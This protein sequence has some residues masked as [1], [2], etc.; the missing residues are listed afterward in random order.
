M[1]R[2]REPK[3][4]QRPT[5]RFADPAGPADPRG[6][7]S[8]PHPASFRDPD[9]FVFRRE[10]V[11]H[12]HVSGPGRVAYDGLMQS[13]LYE[14]LTEAR[15]LLPHAEDDVALSPEPDAYRVLRPRQLPFIS[16]PY[17]WS[18]NQL[19][20]AA[21]LTLEIERRALSR[22][23]TLK[24]ASAYNVQYVDGRSTFI[25]SLS[26]A[27]YVEGTPWAA[28]RQFCGHFLAPLA[29]MSRV[30]LRLGTLLG[31]YLDG[32]PLD[33]AADLLPRRSRLTVSFGV[34]IHAH[35]R[36]SR[37]HESD[38]AP[39]QGKRRTMSRQARMNFVASLEGA[40]RSCQIPSMRTEWSDYYER[41]NYSEAG[42]ATKGQIVADLV[43]RVSPSL[44]WDLG[45][46]TGRFSRICAD[47]GALTV[48]WDADPVAVDQGYRMSRD[49]PVPN[50]LPLIVDLMNPSP[51][52]GWMS[53]ER[54]GFFDRPNPDLALGLGLIHHLAIANNVPL[55]GI[56]ALFARVA[57]SAMVEFV[58]K[59][60]SQ[61]R[62][63][64]ATRPD[65]FP[66]YTYE[67]FR[68]A[69]DRPFEWVA[70]AGVEGS[71]RRIDLFRRR[72]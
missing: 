32:I 30:D 52:R 43:G 18:F 8:G 29:L 63:L 12:R 11:V 67:G 10:G 68:E 71:L 17:E 55:A 20:D 45:A 31:H 61:V 14:E 24:D 40:V 64:L 3:R 38:T 35:A 60:D 39:E 58:P 48:A 6:V 5:T 65:I 46:N 33:L 69:F 15:L 72:P 47:A 56:A 16:H 62:R 50:L 41:T 36:S 49:A 2:S 26:F 9:G 25:D 53:T 59:E 1:Q 54:A 7:A 28:Y 23:L 13:G 22:G 19:R 34:H 42:L 66:E 70:S 4:L 57:P 37:H 44:V 21:L 51:D 27:P